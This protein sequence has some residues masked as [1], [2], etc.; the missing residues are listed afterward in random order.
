[1]A[2]YT[3][4]ASLVAEGPATLVE[5]A[6]VRI[7]AESRTALNSVFLSHSSRDA[8]ILPAVIRILERHGAQVYIDKK[9]TTLPDITSVD[10]ATSL[11]QRIKDCKKLIVLTSANSRDSRW[12]PW[13]LGIADGY[14]TPANLAVW[15]AVDVGK[16]QK[17]PEQEY[18]GL[19]RHVAIGR[20]KG[21]TEEVYMVWDHQSN[22]ATEL[23]SWISG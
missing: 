5:Q 4:R 23:S 8:D 3:T 2:R 12:V 20:I 19:Y 21:Q 17:W 9:D 6:G 15:P 11:K 1:M 10:T 7:S 16:D 13:E 14:K 18:L 22:T